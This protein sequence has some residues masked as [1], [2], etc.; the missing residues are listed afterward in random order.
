[1]ALVLARSKLGLH[2]QARE[3]DLAY[4]R[5]IWADEVAA[6]GPLFHRKYRMSYPVFTKLLSVLRGSLERNEIQARRRHGRGS[7]AARAICPET[8]VAVALRFF[9]GGSYLDIT[10]SHKIQV[11]TFYDIVKRVTSAIH[12]H[13]DFTSNLETEEGRERLS[14]SFS[15]ALP[16]NPL[17]CFVLGAVDGLAV[18]IRGPWARETDAPAYFYGRKGFFSLNVKAVC[19]GA[20]RFIFVKTAA[21][22]SMHDS[23][24]WSLTTLSRRPELDEVLYFNRFLVGDDAYSVRN[25]LLC[26]WAGQSLPMSKDAFNFFLSQVRQT[27]ER[28]FGILNARWG[29]LWRALRVT[30]ADCGNLL[31]ALM[32]LHNFIIDHGGASATNVPAGHGTPAD[33]VDTDE[34]ATCDGDFNERERKECLRRVDWTTRLCR[35]GRVRPPVRRRSAKSLPE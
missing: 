1:L 34:Q 2:V 12:E 31:G 35:A 20:C 13:L 16:R 28:S 17:A 15:E 29:V 6:L 23:F 18:R 32:K 25:N 14:R 22:G 26:P 7:G 19:D 21:P 4:E 3:R 8:Q 24:A 10:T 11:S 5:L 27:I 30:L 33:L 9:A